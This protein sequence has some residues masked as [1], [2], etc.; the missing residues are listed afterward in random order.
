MIHQRGYL[1][2]IEKKYLL[3]RHKNFFQFVPHF[4]VFKYG[5]SFFTENFNSYLSLSLRV[6]GRKLQQMRCQCT[7]CRWTKCQSDEVSRDEVS[8]RQKVTGRNVAGRSVH[9][10]KVTGRN[11]ADTVSP[12]KIT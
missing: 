9:Q 3:L 4:E 2:R 1:E 8:T 11:P 7:K 12:R 5:S 6:V 10:K